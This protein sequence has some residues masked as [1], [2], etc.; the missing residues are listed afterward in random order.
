MA[1]L[2]KLEKHNAER[3]QNYYAIQNS[4]KPHPNGLECPECGAELWD[5][6]P[7]VTLTSSP[8]QK[9]VHCEKCDYIG[10]RID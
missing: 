7:M 8:P 2:K 9:N 5:S 4:Y 6:N 10:Y 1:K 3:H